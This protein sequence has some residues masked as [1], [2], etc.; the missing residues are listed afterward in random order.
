MHSD[1]WLLAVMFYYGTRLTR[2]DSKRLFEIGQQAG[3]MLSSSP[4]RHPGMRPSLTTGK[5]VQLQPVLNALALCRQHLD[6]LRDGV[7]R[8]P[9]RHC[10]TPTAVPRTTPCD[11]SCPNRH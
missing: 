11:R 6:A 1:T 3:S 7:P 9:L 10:S 2:E 8:G 4:A 5:L